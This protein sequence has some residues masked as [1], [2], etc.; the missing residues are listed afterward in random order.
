[1]VSD[2][3][4]WQLLAQQVTEKET[5]VSARTPASS[6]P[7]V[8]GAGVS[9]CVQAGMNMKVCCSALLALCLAFKVG[10]AQ[11][12]FPMQSL[13]C[14]NDYT[15][16]ITCTWQEHKAARRFLN[17]SLYH[18]DNVFMNNTQI[19]CELQR[20]KELPA[21]QYPCVF[22]SCRKNT[23]YFA[24]GIEDIYTF[25]PNQDLQAELTVSLFQNVRP[26][27]PQKFWI[28]VTEAGDFLLAWKAVGGRQG[29]QQ[30]HNALEF[31][32]TYKREWESWEKSSSV[33]VSNSSHYLL[34]RDALVPDST[35]VARVRS[36]PSQSSGWSGQPSE[37][38]TSVTWRSQE[39]YDA[40]PKNL[41]CLFNGFDWLT[42]SWE[43]RRE[44]T[45][46]VLF[47]LFYRATSASNENECSPVQEEKL[48]HSLYLLQSCEI[49][50]T[51][52]SQ[53]SQYF[54]TVRPKKE[55]KLIEAYKNIKPHAPIN[56]TVRK[57]KDQDYMLRWTKQTL[58]YDYITQRYE[59]WFWK[60]GDTVKT[61]QHIN[62]SND[63]PPFTFPQ[64][65]LEPSTNYTGKMRA[66]VHTPSLS[67]TGPWSEWSEECTWETESAL[68]S[69][70][71]L[72]MI[73]V[74]TIMLLAFAWCAYKVLLS[75]KKKWEEKIPNPGKSY[76]LQSYLQKVPLG[77]LHP[78]SQLD[79][80]KLSP[81]QK[82]ELASCIQEL[83]GNMKVSS[84]ELSCVG[85]E[86]MVCFLGA[87]DSK[88]PY[89][90]LEMTAPAPRPS[91]L[92]G[93]RSS[94]G[95][96]QPLLPATLHCRSSAEVAASQAPMSCFD[97]NGPYLHLP[98]TCSLP[99]IHQDWEDARVGT[100]GR[101]VSLDYVC[102]PQEAHSQTL[103]VGAE[104]GPAHFH[105]IS[106][107]AQ[108]EM[109]QPLAGVQEVSQDQPAGGKVTLGDT[110][111]QRSPTA[112]TVINSSQKWPLGY[113]TMEGLSLMP[114]GDSAH[115]S[116]V[117]ALPEGMLSA[118]G[119]LMS[120]P[121]LPHTME[122]TPSPELGPEKPDVTVPVPCSA[123][124]ASSGA[125]LS[126]FGSYIMFPKNPSIPSEPIDVS[127]PILSKGVDIAKAEPV[128]ENNVVMF[129][130]D[131]TGPVF[132]QQVGE[133]C[134]FPGLKPGEKT[135]VSE[136][137]SLTDH[138]SESREAFGKP[139]CDG[140]SVNG[141]R[142]PA[143]HMQAIQL[144]KN[145]KCDDYFVFPLLE[146]Q[147]P[148]V[149]TEEVC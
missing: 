77:M 65:M 60:T 97:F 78:G 136:S 124:D 87:L 118:P 2:P 20:A 98:H 12:S 16:E 116:P 76:L 8:Q 84:S 21:S 86:K 105:S 147:E 63:K 139:L 145:L 41:H 50:V 146:G 23:T 112:V 27:P 82:M 49:N 62:I 104:R 14:Y 103:L 10:E 61:P 66:R 110:E 126:V 69:L 132:L 83:D 3:P 79:F 32:V 99:D 19:P 125:P 122:G 38:S 52:P 34:K 123:S 127:S 18:E 68:S 133:Y 111:G 4:G 42:C 51:D 134:F 25:K 148:A 53:L 119:V 47:T 29:S 71:L 5:R 80:G 9:W 15:S 93:C 74:F 142:E 96:S 58:S 108:K 59:F 13:R 90:T 73:P 30:L 138:T 75:K 100:R 37:W 121:Q 149:R 135:P 22:W 107:P 6:H 137:S 54:I 40:Q 43:V 129:N 89:Q 48:P 144:F 102:L 131:G 44:V 94:P 109:K 28:N 141:K 88:N 106:P 24:T 17:L 92:A 81:S 55:E 91:A 128:Q 36:K 31:E 114:A 140:G 26:L 101:L 67:Y 85:A 72:M 115:L 39:G 117:L 70:I 130:P 7:R 143:L 64:K 33:T 56:V 35:Y 120:N 11:E 1:M 45:S 57:T 113:V 46:S 95:T